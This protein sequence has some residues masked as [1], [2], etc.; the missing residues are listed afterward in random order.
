M[1]RITIL[2]DNEHLYRDVKVEAS[3]EGRTVKDV[4]AEAL[5]DW[6]RRR[7]A[8][9]PS[10][11]ERRQH[12]LRLSEELRARQPVRETIEDTLASIREERS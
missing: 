6:L 5:G 4:V 7:T 9:D 11:R 12:A 3:K 8:L 2:F 10:E 1:K